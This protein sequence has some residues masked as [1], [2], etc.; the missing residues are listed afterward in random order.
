MLPPRSDP[1][2]SML[3]AASF[4][5][6]GGAILLNVMC[7]WAP[8]VQASWGWHMNVTGDDGFTCSEGDSL[9]A[10]WQDLRCED[11]DGNRTL[12]DTDVFNCTVVAAE[13]MN[14]DQTTTALSCSL[15]GEEEV[16][17]PDSLEKWCNN[18]GWEQAPKN[19][20]L[21]L[22]PPVTC[23]ASSSQASDA[24]SVGAKASDATQVGARH[25]VSLAIVLAMGLA[26][27]VC[28]SA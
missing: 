9:G 25:V 3:G 20:G 11:S 1:A 27:T 8:G 21:K 26:G 16:F 24:T 18:L 14:C 6:F 7:A 28:A 5:A 23:S 12:C 19:A 4:A 17:R 22:Y 15:I 13:N 2:R 10:S